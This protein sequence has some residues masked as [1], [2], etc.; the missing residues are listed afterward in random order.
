MGVA[1]RVYRQSV[2][3]K[4]SPRVDGCSLMQGYSPKMA[5]TYP[6]A[7]SVIL[8]VTGAARQYA[9]SEAPKNI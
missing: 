8:T 1:F 5:G 3:P 6:S 9:N 2:F 7:V 4:S